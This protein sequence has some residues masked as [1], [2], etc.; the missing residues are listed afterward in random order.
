MNVVRAMELI[1]QYEV[2]EQCGSRYVANGAGT[3]FID[4]KVFK[5]TCKCGWSVEIDILNNKKLTHPVF[6]F[7]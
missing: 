1:K 3:L 4:E 2:C 5:R 7:I 6:L